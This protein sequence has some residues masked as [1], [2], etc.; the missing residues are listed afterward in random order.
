[1]GICSSSSSHNITPNPN[2]NY[3]FPCVCEMS[4]F[5]VGAQVSRLRRDQH[6]ASFQRREQDVTRS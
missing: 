6:S 1:M 4:I 3:H 5:A 2:P